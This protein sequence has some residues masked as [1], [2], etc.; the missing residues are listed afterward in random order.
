[1]KANL[2]KWIFLF[3][4]IPAI[5]GLSGCETMHTR[6]V[7][8]AEPEDVWS[9]LMD[10]EKYHEWNPVFIKAEG[11]IIEGETLHYQFIDLNNPE[12][13]PVDMET[14]VIKVVKPSLLKQAAGTMGIL[15]AD[16]EY[17]LRMVEGGTEVIQHEEDRGIALLFWDASWVEP[18]Y[19]KALE[20]LKERVILIK[21]RKEK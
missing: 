6:V 5:L 12:A 15:T 13:K 2:N 9:V 7:I 19:Q 18:A 10:T 17:R 20:A 4:M 11:E 21:G 16:H 14:E 1:M 3:I 8:P